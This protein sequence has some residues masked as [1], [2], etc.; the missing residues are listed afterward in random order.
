MAGVSG[1]QEGA[2]WLG[3]RITMGGVEAG[4]YTDGRVLARISSQFPWATFPAEITLL[5]LRPGES[6]SLTAVF[7]SY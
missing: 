6:D 2:R 1:A 4:L 3:T 7:A 5:E